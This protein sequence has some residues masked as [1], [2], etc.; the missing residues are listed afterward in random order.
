MPHSPRRGRL[1]AVDTADSEGP[2]EHL[3]NLEDPRVEGNGTH[4]SIGVVGVCVCPVRR[5]VGSKRAIGTTAPRD[6]RRC[7]SERWS[8]DLVSDVFVPDR[9]LVKLPRA[10]RVA[11]LRYAPP[12]IHLGAKAF[13][14]PTF[15]PDDQGGRS[16]VYPILFFVDSDSCF[17]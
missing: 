15:E 7:G 10:K 2:T 5:R 12:T 4:E 14:A 3:S 9:R 17:L 6:A 13:N 16:R 8:G 11:R 1:P